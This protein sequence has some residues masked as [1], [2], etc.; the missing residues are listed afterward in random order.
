L[1]KAA[2]NAVDYVFAHASEFSTPLLLM[3]GSKDPICLPAGAEKFAS[4]APHVTTLKMWP[5]KMHELH[6]ESRK[7]EAIDYM[8]AWIREKM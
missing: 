2:V 3:Q 6:N 5:G 7:E 1:G 8:V 4:L